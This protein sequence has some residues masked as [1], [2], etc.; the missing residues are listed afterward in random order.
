MLNTERSFIV[1]LVTNHLMLVEQYLLSRRDWF[2]ERN[3]IVVYLFT[4]HYKSIEIRFVYSLKSFGK[5]VSDEG[6]CLPK[7]WNDW[8]G[9]M[10]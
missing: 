2:T 10:H 4:R 7:R 9:R 1:M 3:L 6:A 8:T 5:Q